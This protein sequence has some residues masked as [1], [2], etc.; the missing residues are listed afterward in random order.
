MKHYGEKEWLSYKKGLLSDEKAQM[1]ESH[2]SQCDRCLEDFLSLIGQE[3]ISAAEKMVSPNFSEGVMHAV[4]KVRH[5]PVSARKRLN[6]K[7]NEIFTYYVAAA[8]VTLVLTGS[9][10][11]G[12]LV[13]AVPRV[14]QTA[15]KQNNYMQK[16][17]IIDWSEKVVNKTSNFIDRL[18]EYDKGELK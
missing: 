10:F 17:L 5:K 15:S 3:E 8:L 1:M 2:L 16:N 18:E 12:H 14:E 7:W 9:G 13:Q 11:F 4:G 6:T